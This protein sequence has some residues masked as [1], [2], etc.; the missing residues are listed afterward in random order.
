[1]CGVCKFSCRHLKYRVALCYDNRMRYEM[2][3]PHP[4]FLFCFVLQQKPDIFDTE[5]DYPAFGD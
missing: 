5:A 4:R 2:I 3:P 1:M